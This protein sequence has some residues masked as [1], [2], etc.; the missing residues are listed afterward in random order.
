MI[1]NPVRIGLVGLGTV[2]TGVAKLLLEDLDAIYRRTG[3]RLELACI[4]DQDIKTPRKITLPQGLLS[5]DLNRILMIRVFKS[6]SNWLG[7]K[8]SQTNSGKAVRGR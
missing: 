2:G 5:P 6:A 3:I 8:N 7:D 1:Q 4:V